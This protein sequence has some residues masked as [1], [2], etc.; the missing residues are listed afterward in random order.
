[1]RPRAGGELRLGA[2]EPAETRALAYSEL[3]RLRARHPAVDRVLGALLAQELR[4]HNDLE[5]LA[6]IA[7]TSRATVNR[8]LREEEKRGTLRLDRGR[9]TPTDVETLRRRARVATP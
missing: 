5:E 8:V 7:G 3:E 6:Q 9:T 1:V 2:L 4:R